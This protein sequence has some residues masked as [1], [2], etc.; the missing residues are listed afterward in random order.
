[1]P[2]GIPVT[3]GVTD[4]RVLNHDGFSPLTAGE[5]KSTPCGSIGASSLWL[6]WEPQTRGTLI[7]DTLESTTNTVLAVYQ[8]TADYANPFLFWASLRRVA[9]GHDN[10]PGNTRSQVCF[11]AQPTNYLVAVDAFRSTQDRLRVRWRMVSG[12]AVDN[13][14]SV[15]LEGTNAVICWPDSCKNYTLQTTPDLVHWQDAANPSLVKTNGCW[16]VRQG[17]NRTAKFYRLRG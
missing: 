7:V 14:L 15:T 1:L 9:C 2:A 13:L 3:I 5:T 12:S 8:P 16:C 4:S 11:D 6:H 10:A 17:L